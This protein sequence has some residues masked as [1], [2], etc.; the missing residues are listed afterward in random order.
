MIKFFR[1]IRQNL[2]SEGKTGK[3]IKYAIGE[4]LL[5]VIGILIALQINN[6]NDQRIS[7]KEVITQLKILSIELKDDINLFESQI[8]SYPERVDYLQKLSQGEFEELDL[9]LFFE[10]VVWND[11]PILFGDS[12]ANLKTNGGIDLIDDKDLKNKLGFYNDRAR[13]TTNELIDY[14]RSTALENVDMTVLSYMEYDNNNELVKENTIRVI[15]EKKLNNIINY[16]LMTKKTQLNIYTDMNEFAQKL[17]EQ[18]DEYIQT[19]E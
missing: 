6:W 1:K 10:I 19:L 7:K 5:V 3:Y 14:G 18:L 12:Y 16:Q 9:S 17:K 8:K 15:K 2:L 4:I 13:L 11:T